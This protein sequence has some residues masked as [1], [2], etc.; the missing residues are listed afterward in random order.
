VAARDEDR[1]L[2]RLTEICLALPEAAR[3]ISG[4]HA[5]FRVGKRTFGELAYIGAR[6]WV[7]LRLDA[8]RIDWDLVAELVTDSY[9][10]VAPKRL[11]GKVE[12]WEAD[13]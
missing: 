8:G 6:G 3:E 12:P 5:S 13:S 4:R 11:A 2:T 9:L 7:G 10:L 1:R